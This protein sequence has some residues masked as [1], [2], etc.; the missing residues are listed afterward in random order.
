MTSQSRSTRWPGGK[1]CFWRNYW[2]CEMTAVGI[3]VKCLVNKT[4]VTT[5]LFSKKSNMR[6]E[7]KYI[8]PGFY[9]SKRAAHSLIT[10]AVLF[11]DIWI[12]W[13]SAAATPPLFDHWLRRWVCVCVSVSV[14]VCSAGVVVAAGRHWLTLRAEDGRLKF[15]RKENKN[16]TADWT[17]G[18]EMRLK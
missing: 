13:S 2:N 5:W 9:E 14:S 6:A 17:K 16:S 11:E 3:C 10:L 18:E 12:S 1:G 4:G 8:T 7:H 15:N